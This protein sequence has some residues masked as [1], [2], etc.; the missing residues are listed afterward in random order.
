MFCSQ[1]IELFDVKKCFISVE[2]KTFDRNVI[3]T[4]LITIALYGRGK[5]LL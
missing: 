2:Y 5:L 4:I 3:K 1:I